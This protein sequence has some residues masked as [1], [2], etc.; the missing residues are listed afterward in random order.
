MS[1]DAS[2]ETYWLYIEAM[3]ELIFSVFPGEERSHAAAER[4]LATVVWEHT[5]LFHRCLECIFFSIVIVMFQLILLYF[6]IIHNTTSKFDLPQ[7]PCSTVCNNNS[8]VRELLR[9]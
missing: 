2:P 7:V 4:T 3:Q 5:I 6:C 1:V 9:Q 8:Q